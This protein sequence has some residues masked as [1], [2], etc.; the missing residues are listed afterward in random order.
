MSVNA[1]DL[2][3]PEK[4]SFSKE[5]K[6]SRPRS[7]LFLNRFIPVISFKLRETTLTIFVSIGELVLMEFEK[8]RVVS[9]GTTEMSEITP[10]KIQ[11]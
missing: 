2:D 6:V 3:Q 5:F 9:L 7:L 4:L 11:S 8:V 10:L 1:L